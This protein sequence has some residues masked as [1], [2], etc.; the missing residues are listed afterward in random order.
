LIRGAKG[1]TVKLT[2]LPA[3]AAD[4]SL[5]KTVSLVRDEIKL[6]DQ[7]AKARIL[8]VPAEQGRTFRVGVIDLPSFYADMGGRK[9]AEPRSA[10][11]DVA[12][13]W[14]S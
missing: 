9:G 10:T 2:I 11:A 7:Q 4:G 12:A 13:C 1:T 3:G 6:E 5:A 14:P 8:D